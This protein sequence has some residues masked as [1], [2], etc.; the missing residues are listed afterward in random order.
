MKNNFKIS[1]IVST[2]NR[3]DALK[4]V[5]TSLLSQRDENFEIVVA[6]DG[7]TAPTKKLVEG[8]EKN[9]PHKIVHVWHPDTGF[10]LSEIRNKAAKVSSGQYLLI[11]DGDCVPT[12]DW[13]SEN[14]KLAEPGWVVAGQRVLLSEE[15]TKE[16][17]SSPPIERLPVTLAEAK[18]LSNRK[19]I[20]RWQPLLRLPLGV[21][22]KLESSNWK[23]ARTFSL[24]VWRDDFMKVRGFDESFVGWGH[25]DADLAV[26]LINAGIRI[27]LGTFSS[28]VFHLWHPS[29]PRTN[30]SKN[31]SIVLQR[32]SSG[33]IFPTQGIQ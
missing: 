22:R 17:L 7:S 32:A 20:N 28:T 29:A 26:R 23:K 15:F 19:I 1:V 5:L 31:W 16:L 10:R 8:Y 24:G 9:Y 33:E 6:D 18:D 2:Y 27:K 4:A 3:P 30:A 21:L 14:R 25:D 11:V 13:I 12:Q